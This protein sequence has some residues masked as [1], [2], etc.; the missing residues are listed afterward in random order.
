MKVVHV[1]TRLILG[2]AQENTLFTVEG[3]DKKDYDVTLVTGPALGPEGSLIERAKAN[4]VKLV[5]VRSLRREIS[6]GYDLVA[7]RRLLKYFRREKPTIVHTHS[8]KAGVLGRL[9]ARLAKVPVI[10]HTI[11]GMPFHQYQN[12]AAN[13]LF[14]SIE[15]LCAHYTDR[16]VTVAQAMTDQALKAGLAPPHKFVKILSGMEVEKFLEAGGRKE[17]RKLFGIKE[18][19]FVIG[20]IARLFHLKGHE[21]IME[22]APRVLERFPNVKFLFV[23]EGILREQLELLADDLDIGGHFLFAGLTDPEKIPEMIQAMDL[24]VHTSLREGLARVLP[25]GLISGKPVISYDIDGA[26][27]VVRNGETGYLVPP[28]TVTELADAIIRIL[29]N[30]KKAREMG[31]RGRALFAEA[32]RKEVMV[33]R[34]DKLYRELCK[35]K[36]IPWE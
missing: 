22:A 7:F 9:A 3:L 28:E 36:G 33:E 35:E 15:K 12:R 17:V 31:A 1:I 21:Y 24:L 8:S 18:N 23:G 20:T 10:L 11:H 16:I 25:Q 26:K 27:E 5:V 2:G 29:E 19:E 13:A 14:V 6:P 4:G 32:F 30:P 34:I